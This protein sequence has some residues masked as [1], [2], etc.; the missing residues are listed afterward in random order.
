MKLKKITVAV[1]LLITIIIAQ[2]SFIQ[3]TSFVT[4]ANETANLEDAKKFHY[5]QL[6]E[7]SKRIY[8]ALVKMKD[9]GILKTG[10]ENYDLV[11]NGDLTSEE[12]QSYETGNVNLK[13]EFYAARYAFYADYPEVF[14]MSMDKLT[15]RTTKDANGG[16]HVYIGAGNNRNYLTEG[17]AD[18]Q[19]VEAAIVE[20][21]E[22]VTQMV[23]NANNLTIAEG[24]N[25]EQ[26]K[27]KYVHNQ[28]I[29]HAGY[30]YETDCI[31]GNEGFLGTPYGILV[32]GEG[33]CEGYARA[34]KTI[35]DRLN[36]DCILVQ[37]IH[38]SEG[39]SPVAHMW[40]YVKLEQEQT[41]ARA[42]VEEKWYAVDVTL[43]DPF[44]RKVAVEESDEREPGWDIVEGFEN[45]KY[46]FV[47][48]ETMTAEHRA[49]EKVEAAGNYLFQYP[50]L[51]PE[52]LGIELVADI[53]GLVV[54]YK[55]DG[56]QT[57]EY[58]AGDYWISY[59]GKGYKNAAETENAYMLIKYYQYE[60]GD[61]VWLEGKWGYLDP[62]SYASDWDYEDHV[63]LPVPNGEYMQFAVTTRKPDEPS[64][65]NV[66]N[67]VYQGDES[68]FIAKTEKLFNP[69]GTYKG[70]PYIKKQTPAAT[71]SL[72]I[73]RTYKITVI[74]DDDL[75]FKEGVTQAGYKVE[76]TGTSGA[77]YGKIE[78]FQFDGKRTVTYN[79]TPSKMFA[80]DGA[81]YHV[82]VT[83]VVGKNSG[84]EPMEI[85]YGAENDVLCA[86]RMNAARNWELFARPN[87]MADEDLSL[88][89]WKTDDGKSVSEKLKNRI[90]LV[91]TRTT[92][93]EKESMN[94][95]IENDL[96]QENSNQEILKSE[97]YNLSLNAC[98][99]YV[100]KT[101]HRVRLSVGFPAG[102]GP[103]DAGVT[104]KAYHFKKDEQ[105]NV[106]EIEEIPCIV[107]QYGLIITCDSF[108]PFAIAAVSGEETQTTNKTK[109]LILSS[110]ENGIMTAVN[111]KDNQELKAAG[112]ILT[113]QENDSKE[114]KITPNAGY[115]IETIT[116][117]GEQIEITN[118]KQMNLTVN[119]N[120]IKDGNVI[121]DATF[122]AET[123][124]QAEEARGETVVTPKATPAQ[125]TMNQKL[126]DTT[127]NAPFTIEP[128]V[129]EAV[130]IQ[131]YQWYKDG[132]KLE[133]KTNKT[134]Q[135][136]NPVAEDSG[137][138][139]LK[140]TNTVE[141]SSEETTS[142]VCKVVVSSFVTTLNASAQ[143]DVDMQ[144]LEAGDEFEV[145]INIGDFKNI[146]KG[147]YAI[148][149]KLEYSKDLLEIVYENTESG[150]KMVIAQNGWDAT[151]ENEETLK[152]VTVGNNITTP[153]T[154]GKIKFKVKDVE[155]PV[156]ATIK[157]VQMCASDTSKDINAKDANLTLTVNPKE[158]P[159]VLEDKLTSDVYTVADEIISRVEA[160]TTIQ[161][162]TKNIT[163]QGTLVFKDKNGNT[164]TDENAIL[165][166]GITL[167]VGT[168]LHYTIC[169][170]GDID[171]NG[172]V[173]VT[174]LAQLML[175]IVEAQVLEGIQF[176]AADMNG[177]GELTVT[178][179]AQVQLA[180]VGL[181][182]EK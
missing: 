77:E 135:I 50:P 159:P 86:S 3:L 108:S 70:K 26:E 33:V 179:I 130:G 146:A 1:V 114:F 182:I 78:N 82:Y 65:S 174:D 20:F 150:K 128:T 71:S 104:F 157:L 46:L 117:C 16:Y 31:P 175:H 110:S 102:Y 126:V 171:G 47:G 60:P 67:L 17:F 103:E 181:P 2:F 162:F 112:N 178:D 131:T 113:F 75:V 101:G 95:L 83:G 163:S 81:Y 137:D 80:D 34:F 29:Q 41:N 167:D 4:A 165:A 156:E 89:G 139:C 25:V 15:I 88:S 10:T 111:E 42:A 11:T 36:I 7:I 64:S 100:I 169:V 18:Q 5:N 51:S 177:N 106:T 105:G 28:I 93:S 44:V 161:E 96:K 153:G 158:E 141:T 19:A 121:V 129:S 90:A 116:V 138:Y 79:F 92:L 151:T 56:N 58:T 160:G 53:N 107:T 27:I 166:T 140:V 168:T 155:N 123:V 63:Y 48:E 172:E 149:G 87:L 6:G 43:D 23:E 14:Y 133:G 72:A 54:R 134:L 136:E 144:K 125:V 74:Y 180:I 127:I 164:I 62:T 132:V 38:Q 99:Q 40:N 68:D 148:Q 97:T 59:N 39:Q 49:I 173:T 122:V 152:F 115:Q 109:Q 21:E 37:G 170:T 85:S 22:K 120:D 24:K 124:A 61:E 30:R 76:S 57:I 176:K 147:L 94:D 73:G 142:E 8:Q 55:K 98:K 143:E 145:A 91:T 45:T 35:L 84:K 32:K 9:N 66:N 118:A 13:K 12:V 154:M 69:N 119:Y 52:D